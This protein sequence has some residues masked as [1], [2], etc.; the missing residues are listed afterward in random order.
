MKIFS[1]GQLQVVNYLQHNNTVTELNCCL[2]CIKIKFSNSLNNIA[3]TFSVI[4]FVL[5]YTMVGPSNEYA[6]LQDKNNSGHKNKRSLSIV[7]G[8]S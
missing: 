8:E 1:G 3:S 6:V 2:L 4:C 5:Q 7:K